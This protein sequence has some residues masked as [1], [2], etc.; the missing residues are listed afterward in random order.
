MKHDAMK[1]KKNLS[2]FL[3]VVLLNAFCNI[4]VFAST[5]TQNN[6]AIV[7]G[8]KR[9]IIKYK[10]NSVNISKIEAK[11]SASIKHKYKHINA[12]TADLTPQS[13][14][15]LRKDSNVAY[16]QEDYPV[17]ISSTTKSLTALTTFPDWGVNDIKAPASWQSGLTGAGTK[18][19]IIDSGSGP[20]ED[21]IVKGGTNVIFDSA[22]TS[23]ADDNG[24]GTHV[25][26]IIAAQGLNGYAKGAAPGASIYA[27]KALDS[28]GN[29]Y[30]SDVISGIDWAIENGMNIIT[31]SFGTSESDISLE[32]AV[33]TA[34]NDGILVVGAAGNDGNSEGTGINVEYPAN[35]D[36]VIAVG[37]VDST[38]TRASFSATGSKIEV[39]APGVD[40]TSTYLNDGYA[41]M[42]GTSM[43]APFVAADLA[44][45]KQK[46]PD[47]TNAQLRQLLDNYVVD[48]GEAGRDPLYGYGL[49]VAPEL[50]ASVSNSIS[51]NRISGRNR[52]STATEISKAGWK[53]TSDYAVIATGEDFPDAL[54]AAPLAEKY[55]A[56]IILTEK[57]ALNTDAAS[58]LK[59]LNVKNVF[60]IGGTGAVS[61]STE[62]QIKALGIST[63][64][65]AGATRYETSEKVAEKMGTITKVAIATGNDF[66]DALSISSIAAMKG[67]PILLTERE[68]VPD[69]IK[70]YLTKNNALITESYVVGGIGVISDSVKN[71]LKNPT[72]LAG[73]N[74][75]DTNIAVLNQF[76]SDLSM[77]NVYISTGQNFPD[78]LA[79]S[80]LVPITKSPLLLID[81]S[82]AISTKVYIDKNI[83]S[84]GSVTAVGGTGA[85]S[86]TLLQMVIDNFV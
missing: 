60:L 25:A 30:T 4:P 78:A 49:I 63:I 41:Q 13:L 53:T 51:R 74:R 42:S 75:Y 33:N 82:V 57:D 16:V 77:S 71:I 34:Y 43:A 14:A 24:H 66:P 65:I 15:G 27:V 67:M 54:C 7:S 17:N 10:T 9:Y 45:L 81:N 12:A 76:Q 46:Y 29:G 2:L 58:E 18:I 69:T 22:T 61:G 85:V 59:R 3:V 72:R 26:G 5:P 20:H 31:M 39:S 79:C 84:I 64:R 23:Y 48:L 6:N 55:N 36:S 38:N 37:A 83:S 86:D 70:G 68:F 52:Y 80:V 19:A 8:T 28:A 44:L 35:Y 73:N 47:Y 40:I 32:D 21:L 1:F 56:P 11:Y 62:N 50:A